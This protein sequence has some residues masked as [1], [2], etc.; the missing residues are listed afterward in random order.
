MKL[1]RQVHPDGQKAEANDHF[2]GSISFDRGQAPFSLP[3]RDTLY[4]HIET[5]PQGALAGVSFQRHLPGATPEPIDLQTDYHLQ[6]AKTLRPATRVDNRAWIT[7]RFKTYELLRDGDGV[8][9]KI[10]AQ[11]P[12][13]AVRQLMRKRLTSKAL[14]VAKL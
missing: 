13:D 1:L 4:L 5:H 11:A 6:D 2:L 7:G 10:D 3:L 8:I 9:Y 12:S 14:P